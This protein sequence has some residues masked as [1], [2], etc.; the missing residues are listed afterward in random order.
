MTTTANMSMILPTDHGDSDVWGALINTALTLND[1]HDHSPG[2]GVKVPTAGLNINADLSFSPTG[3]PRA[4]TDL[5]AIDFAAV[6]STSVTGLA[7]ALFISDGTG[8]LAANELYYRTVLGSNVQF[9]V[10]AAL[11]VAAFAG[12]I[13]GDYI[14]SLAL[15]SYDAASLSYWHQ[16]PGAPRPWARMRSGDVDIYETAASIVNRVRLKSPAALAASYDVTWPAAVPGSTLLM[17]MSSAGVLTASNATIG[18]TPNFTGAVT[19]ASTL[20][21]TGIVTAN[22]IVQANLGIDVGTN[23][24]VTVH[25]TG[26]FKHGTRERHYHISAFQVDSANGAFLTFNQIGYMTGI[27]SVCSFQC[28]LGLDVGKRILSYQQTYDVAGTGAGIQPSIKRINVATG[29]VTDVV[30][31]VNDS[32]GTGIETQSMNSINHTIAVGFAYYIFVN[33]T[34]A[35]HRIYG[36]YIAYDEP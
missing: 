22:A 31:G 12:G 19:M 17:Q 6:A 21:V 2:K 15:L 35:S 23:Q 26:S 13:G 28:P 36:A 29:A 11:N 18:G 3:T 16:Q 14:A 25:G 24:S 34:N 30:L 27:S 10:G 8:G 33:V 9:S 5:K 1:S 20:A 4:L 7:G 32:S